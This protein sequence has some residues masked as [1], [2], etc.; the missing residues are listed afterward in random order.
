MIVVWCTLSVVI[1]GFFHETAAKG[2]VKQETGISYLVDFSD[3]A[4]KQ[5]YEGDYSNYTV[6]KE[7]CL[8]E[9]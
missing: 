8:E 1:G 5:G 6:K 4:K 3:Y 9:K 7:N 2:K